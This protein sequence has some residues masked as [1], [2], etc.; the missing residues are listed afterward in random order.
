MK[1]TYT[2][3]IA[4]TIFIVLGLILLSNVLP[5]QPGLSNGVVGFA[6]VDGTTKQT[7]DGVISNINGFFVRGN[8]APDV[9]EKYLPIYIL[10]NILFI[11]SVIIAFYKKYKR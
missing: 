11:V 4:A 2:L 6:V 7:N 3:G 10:L 9:K 5:S 1:S 8:L